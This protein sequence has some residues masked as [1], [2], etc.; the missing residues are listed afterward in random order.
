M[1]TKSNFRVADLIVT[2]F[3]VYLWYNPA[4]HIALVK[5]MF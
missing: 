2:A 3:L 1:N 5:V 4:V